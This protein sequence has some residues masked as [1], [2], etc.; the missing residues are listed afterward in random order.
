MFKELKHLTVMGMKDGEW[1]KKYSVTCL[2]VVHDALYDI[3]LALGEDAARKAWETLPRAFHMEYNW[4][5][6]TYLKKR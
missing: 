3:Q 5:C 6:W 4:S 1:P 2:S